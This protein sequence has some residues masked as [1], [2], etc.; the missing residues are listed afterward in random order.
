MLYFSGIGSGLS[1]YSGAMSASKRFLKLVV[2]DYLPTCML[3]GVPV[4]SSSEKRNEEL[5]TVSVQFPKWMLSRIDGDA[6]DARRS[7]SAEVV[8]LIE[9][10]YEVNGVRK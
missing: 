9:Q 5:Q 7:R 2:D 6:R 1:H 10:I 8:F 3:M 4:K